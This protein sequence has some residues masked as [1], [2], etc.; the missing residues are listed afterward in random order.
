MTEPRSALPP[1]VPRPLFRGRLSGPGLLRA[2]RDLL[3]RRDP[4]VL[5]RPALRL[6]RDPPGP[7]APISTSSAPLVEY[8]RPLRFDERFEVE[9]G[10]RPDRPHQPDLRARALRRAARREPRATAEMVWV[11]ADQAT[12]RAAPL[13][14]RACS[15]CC[16]LRRDRLQPAGR[17]RSGSRARRARSRSGP[18][19]SGPAHGRCRRPRSPRPWARAGSS[20]PRS[21]PAA[22]RSSMPRST[23]TGQRI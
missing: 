15:S 3:R 20:R 1:R 8:R 2:L 12:M 9:V 16:A 13:P 10:A 7:P 4:R 22:G 14:E 6:H 11:H 19:P 17:S 23:S 18:W 21:R 5:P